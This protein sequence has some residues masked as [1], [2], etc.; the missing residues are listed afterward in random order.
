[1][2]RIVFTSSGVIYGN[3]ENPKESDYSHL[4]H[5]EESSSLAMGKLTS[6]YLLSQYCKKYK[7]KLS[8]ARCFSFVGKRLPINIHYAIGN[9]V[10]DAINERPI[11]IKGDGK[12][13]FGQ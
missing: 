5:I 12:D 7:V 3:K 8:I 13:R 4:N 11:I 6:E 2:K 1:M 10:N 9:F